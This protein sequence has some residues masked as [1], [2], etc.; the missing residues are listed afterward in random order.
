MVNLAFRIYNKTGNTLV[1]GAVLGLNGLFRTNANSISDPNIVFDN[2]TKRFFASLMDITNQSIKVAVSAPNDPNPSTWNVFNF[3]IGRCPDQPFIT[4][5]SNKVAVSF[6][7]FT[8]P[9]VA[10]FVGAQTL[11]INKD[12]MI[13]ARPPAFHLTGADANGFREFPVRTSATDERI[14]LVSIPSTGNGT[15]KLTTF[16]GVITTVPPPPAA[17]SSQLVPFLQKSGVPNVPPDGLQP[18]VA[19]AC[20]KGNVAP[21]CIDTADAHITGASMSPDNKVLWLTFPEACKNPAPAPARQIISCIRL[22]ELDTDA[23]PIGA[24]KAAIKFDFDLAERNM[25]LY[26]PTLTFTGSRAQGTNNMIVSFGGSN[27]TVFPSLFASG[28]R[29]PVGLLLKPSLLPLVQLKSGGSPHL[30][31]LGPP[32]VTRYGDYFGAE[33]I[34]RIVLSVGWLA[35]IC[36][37]LQ[38]LLQYRFHYGLLY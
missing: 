19:G 3:R 37:H 13:N 29:G 11:L 26:Y 25:D 5:S 16:T 23:S 8:S 2:S 24:A 32:P 33:L 9:C 20:A 4:V 35:N 7:T 6:N 38:Y 17:T 21:P 27:T 31:L 1:P 30:P 14:F 15:I 34:Q 28:Q 22:I 12:D 36:K 10:P 18:G